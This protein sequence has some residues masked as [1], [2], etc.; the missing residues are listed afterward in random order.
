MFINMTSVKKI[1]T[2]D[3]MDTVQLEKVLT[4]KSIVKVIQ[5]APSVRVAIGELF[6]YEPGTPLTNKLIGA[7]RKLGFDFVF[8]TT[9]AADIVVMEEDAELEQRLA[10]GGPFP[11]TNSCCPGFVVDLE[12]DFPELREK[13]MASTKSPMETMGTLIKTYFAAKQSIDPKNIYSVAAMPCLV[14]K[15]EAEKPE[16]LLDGNLQVVDLVLTT[17]ET[18]QL[19]K[20]KG[21]YLKD[22]PKSDFDMLLGPSSGAAR[23]FGVSGGVSEATLRYHARRHNK[24]LTEP[25]ISELRGY[26]NTREIKFEMD[27]KQMKML[28]IDGVQNAEPVLKDRELREQYHFIEVMNC[29]GGC[30]GGAGQPPATPEIIEKRRKGL[31]SL[32]EKAGYSDS[33]QNPAATQLYREFLGEVGG[34]KAKKLLH[35]SN[36]TWKAH[37]PIKK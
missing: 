32:G 23:L 21:I 9:F 22:C 3:I 19:L 35:L 11:L 5:M 6:G 17:V 10:K 7:F 30:I 14:K 16:L 18:A 1:R 29:R 15:L 20:S 31:Y 37:E 27:G 24:A 36:I 25:E 12:R 26:Q 33:G 8:D 34:E 2:G 13:N 4:D 28:V